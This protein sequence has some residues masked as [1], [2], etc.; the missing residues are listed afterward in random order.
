MADMEE[1]P[2]NTHLNWSLPKVEF[3]QDKI[4]QIDHKGR[5]E[6]R[7]LLDSNFLIGRVSGLV[8]GLFMTAISAVQITYK[9][10]KFIG[11]GVLYL[12][13]GAVYVVD[14]GKNPTAKAS[15][16]A[17]KELLKLDGEDTFLAGLKLIATVVGT[18]AMIIKQSEGRDIIYKGNALNNKVLLKKH[19]VAAEY[20]AKSEGEQGKADELKAIRVSSDSVT[21]MMQ[22]LANQNYDTKF[23]TEVPDNW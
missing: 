1:V 17:Q 7:E 9:A 3:D 4:S 13:S 16:L 5:E 22:K 23:T 12:G 20:K 8:V 11:R 14:L 10:T 6:F 15:Y 2:F 18:V 21:Q 19:I